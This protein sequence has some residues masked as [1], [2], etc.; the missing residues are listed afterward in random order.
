MSLIHLD[1]VSKSFGDTRA[2]SNVTF[3]VPEGQ[4][5]GFIGPNGSGK[6]T[7]IL[8]I[9]GFYR[10]DEGSVSVLGHDP[11]TEWPAIGRDIGVSLEHQGLQDALTATESLRFF[12][13]LLRVPR[14]DINERV[15]AALATVGMTAH[16][17]VR[18]RGFS[19]GMRQRIVLARCLLKAPRCLILDEPFDGLDV[20]ARRVITGVLTKMA[21]NGVGVFVTSHDLH[22]VDRLCHHVVIVDRGRVVAA[23]SPRCIRR[24]ATHGRTLLIDVGSMPAG[25][26]LEQLVA[27]TDFDAGRRQLRVD[28][29]A[30]GRAREAV[31]RDLIDMGVSV[32]AARM[33]EASLEDAFLALTHGGDRP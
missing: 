22:E 20:E 30:C 31:L 8:T 12:A 6:T 19:K 1:G 26:D 5:V 16:A 11:L 21:A 13:G 4:I 3:A 14:A 25:L 27:G 29:G 10:P 15:A 28:L 7:A 32:E 23:D 18:L 24:A 2:L 9:L 17:G 33:E